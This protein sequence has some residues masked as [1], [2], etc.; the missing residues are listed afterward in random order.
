MKRVLLGALLFF[1]AAHGDAWAR[2]KPQSCGKRRG[3]SAAHV[4][5]VVSAR[6]MRRQRRRARG[7]RGTGFVHLEVAPPAATVILD[8][9]TYPGGTRTVEGVRVGWVPI[10]VRLEGVR[11]VRGYVFVAP[12]KVSRVR[13]VFPPMPGDVTVLSKPEG[14]QVYVDGAYRG[15][16]PLTLEDLPGGEHRL[17]LVGAG[18]LGWEGTVRVWG[19]TQVVRAELVE[20]AGLSEAVDG[21]SAGSVAGVSPRAPATPPASAATPPAPVAPPTPVE[22]AAVGS[23]SPGPEGAHPVP[24]ATPPA[25][26]SRPT[27]SASPAVRRQAAAPSAPP[28]VDVPKG[29]VRLDTLSPRARQTVWDN[30]VGHRAELMLR[31]GARGRADVVGRADGVV[32]V[33]PLAGGAERKVPERDIVAVRRLPDEAPTRAAGPAPARVPQSA[34]APR[35]SEASV[36]VRPTGDA[37]SLQALSPRLRAMVWKRLAGKTVEVTLRTGVRVRVQVGRT[38]G[39]YVVL[40]LAGQPP[41]L[42]PMEDIVAVR[43]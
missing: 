21:S 42:V 22:P 20:G 35:A 10:E 2:T 9:D 18:G 16:S 26:R 1:A 40:T 25:A 27:A 41:R 34:P 36:H 31:S 38:E 3:I 14:A 24:R 19:G 37:V 17:R 43:E 39:E 32:L 30:L 8:G 13:V 7:L 4:E 15:T 5:G 23:A 6:A 33:R 29:M 28:A 12:L 11:P